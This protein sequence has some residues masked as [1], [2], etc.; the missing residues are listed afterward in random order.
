MHAC[1]VGLTPPVPPVAAVAFQSAALVSFIVMDRA[2]KAAVQV[3][4]VVVVLWARFAAHLAP[5]AALLTARVCGERVGWQRW[6]AASSSL[7]V[8]CSS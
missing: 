6:T 7:V 8:A 3:L 2:I 1:R 5:V 4:P